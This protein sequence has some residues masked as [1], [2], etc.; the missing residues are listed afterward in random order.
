MI[1]KYYLENITI[2]KLNYLELIVK[3]LFYSPSSKQQFNSKNRLKR[4]L[5]R[6]KRNYTEIKN[7]YIFFQ[8]EHFGPTLYPTRRTTKFNSNCDQQRKMLLKKI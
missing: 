5:F 4:N 8:G 7:G 1:E 2:Q 6:L 3:L